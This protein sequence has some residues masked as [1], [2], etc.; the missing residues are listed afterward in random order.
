LYAE[1]EKTMI[2]FTG[3]QQRWMQEEGWPPR[4]VNPGT[5]EEFVLLHAGLFERVR[6]V[7]E[8]EDEVAAIEEMYP[9]VSEA[10]DCDDSTS[11]ESA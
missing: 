10:I 8:V 6:Q 4:A 2:E 11:R 5:G 3:E 1:K 7:L 9:A